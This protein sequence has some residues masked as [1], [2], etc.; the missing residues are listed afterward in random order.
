MNGEKHIHI[1]PDGQT[2]EH[3]HSYAHT[4]ENAK[5]VTDRLARAIGHLQKVKKMVEEGEDCSQVLVQLSAVR[6][7]ITNTSKIILK[8]HLEHCMVEAVH[9]GDLEMVRELSHAVDLMIK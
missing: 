7:A 1:L 9:K 5:I 4:H 3:S 8:D 2:L 6:S